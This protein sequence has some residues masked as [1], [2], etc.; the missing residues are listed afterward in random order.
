LSCHFKNDRIGSMKGCEIDMLLSEMLKKEKLNSLEDLKKILKDNPS[1]PIHQ[2]DEKGYTPLMYACSEKDDN[3]SM[4]HYLLQLGSDPNY[5]APDGKSPLWI[6]KLNGN[7]RIYQ[8]L[9]VKGANENLIDSHKLIQSRKKHTQKK[10]SSIFDV[11][12]DG[13]YLEKRTDA[14]INA[15]NNMLDFIKKR[16]DSRVM[17]ILTMSA[18]FTL[19]DRYLGRGVEIFATSNLNVDSMTL[20][21]KHEKTRGLFYVEKNA[22][23]LGNIENYQEGAKVLLHEAT[24]NIRRTLP[25]KNMSDLFSAFMELKKNMRGSKSTPFSAWMDYAVLNRIQFS[26]GYYT[27]ESQLEELIADYPKALLELHSHKNRSIEE[28][29]ILLP[30]SR[31]FDKTMAPQIASYIKNHKNAMELNLNFSPPSNQT[32][33][34]KREDFSLLEDSII[35]GDLLLACNQINEG[36]NIHHEIQNGFTPL[37]LA[38]LAQNRKWDQYLSRN[39]QPTSLDLIQHLVRAGAPINQKAH[40]GS[41][42]LM[43]A[44]ERGGGF[45]HVKLLLHL[46]ADFSMKDHEGNT[47]L[48]YALMK[49]NTLI[50]E[51]ISKLQFHAEKEESK[52]FYRACK[53]STSA[54]DEDALSQL[55]TKDTNLNIRDGEGNT[56]LILA[57]KNNNQKLLSFLIEKGADL[58]ARDHLGRTP[59]MVSICEKN[60]AG[61]F[62]LLKNNAQKDARDYYGKSPMIL[63]AQYG[64]TSMLKYLHQKGFGTL[65][66]R[67]AQ[68]RTP[69]MYA[70]EMGH[71]DTVKELLHLGANVNQGDVFGITPLICATIKNDLLSA[72]SLLKNGANINTTDYANNTPLHN[73]ANHKNEDMVKLLLSYGGDLNAKDGKGKTSR[74]IIRENLPEIRLEKSTFF[75]FD[76]KKQIITFEAM[77]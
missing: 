4:V 74:E 14:G 56:P 77:I 28:K 10:A 29:E 59:L 50:G 73:A 53:N 8:F 15:A 2:T 3:P 35:K 61:A 9:T 44:C 36:A 5:I 34:E 25:E 13:I 46:G 32:L 7:T 67:S 58:E 52:L 24:H 62:E 11:L 70:I 49:G 22:L 66:D 16:G 21:E 48:E 68:L 45:D 40:D 12:K 30:L 27:L 26:Q 69:L 38:V 6:A 19:E 43:H 76:H 41:T 71:E 39:N 65:N 51:E 72:K 42:P 63:A 75:P 33:P 37:F 64:N 57:I 54:F 55:L 60:N 20:R 17:N 47:P 1:I 31:F 23:L 18:L